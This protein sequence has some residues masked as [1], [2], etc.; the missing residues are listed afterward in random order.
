MVCVLLQLVFISAGRCSELNAMYIYCIGRGTFFQLSYSPI[1]MVI[2]SHGDMC[3]NK[4][5]WCLRDKTHMHS[6]GTLFMVKG[7]VL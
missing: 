4:F 3:K 5:A 2:V 6:D 1:R 7:Q